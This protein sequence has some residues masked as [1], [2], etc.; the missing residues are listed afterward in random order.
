MQ[1]AIDEARA[2]LEGAMVAVGHSRRDAAIIADHLMDCELRGVQF[3]GLPRALS[4]VERIEGRADIRKP[5]TVT[6]ETPVSAFV[7]GGDQVGYLVGHRAAEL[8]IERAK[9][10]GIGIVGANDTWFTGMFSYYMEMATCE[11]FV[12]MAIGNASPRVAPHGSTEGRFGTNP[13]SFGFPTDG[14]P[15]IWDIGTS[16]VMA[17]EVA[18]ALRMGTP[19]LE[20]RAFDAKGNPT[21]DPVEA[22]KGA[23]A[24]WG[25]HKGSGLAICVQMLGMMAN[26]LPFPP[27][28]AGCGFIVMA[29]SPGMFMDVAEYKKNASDYAASVREAKPVDAG[30][31]VRMPFDRSADVRRLSLQR[32]TIEVSELVYDRLRAVSTSAR[33]PAA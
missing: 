20:G 12:G 25:G 6:R 9:K 28:L 5:I 22:G 19:L 15:V 24:V 29:M 11:D 30:H 18:L 23:Y 14:D 16:A 31:R 8:A 13:I 4:I 21:R 33:S 27:L 10:N 2:L 17:G 32:G 7:E 26:T 3:G 1:I